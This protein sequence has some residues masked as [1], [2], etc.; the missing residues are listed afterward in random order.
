MG[1]QKYDP[2]DL[3]PGPSTG[4]T[5]PPDSFHDQM[6]IPLSNL[7]AS[8]SR[9]DTPRYDP[10]HAGAR[11]DPRHASIGS[12]DVLSGI[13]RKMEHSYQEFDPSKNASEAHLAF[14]EGDLPNNKASKL[15]NYL[16]N[17]SIVSRW[18]LFIVPVM[19][20]IWIPGIIVLTSTGK[21]HQAQASLLATVWGVGLLWWSI[22]LSVC[23]GGWWAALAASMILPRIIR[24]TVGVIAVG[25]RRYMDWLQALHRYCALFFWTLAV[26]ISYNPLINSRQLPTASA[27]SIKI[28]DL[29]QK[30][31]FAF[32]LCAAVLLGEKFSIQWIAGKFHE[33]SYA[34]RIADQKFAIKSIVTLYTHSRNIARPDALQ[35]DGIK[36]FMNPR[37]F[38]KRALK[39][40]RDA[41]TT[42]TTAFGNV[43]SEITGSS[44]L[45]PNSPQSIVQTALESANRSRLLAR[46]LF[47]SFA[48]PNADYI[49][50]EDIARFF[51]TPDEADLVFALFDQDSN[52]DA[53]RDEVEMAMMEFHREQ[54][55]IE[56]SMQDLDSA[57]GRLDNIFMSLYVV[58]AILIIAVALEAQVA[59]LVTSAGTLV[60]GLSWLIGGTL[61]EVLTSIIFLFIKHPF[62]V[63]DRVCIDKT[64]YTVKE[65]RL[66][67]TIFLNSDGVSVQAPNTV[68]NSQMSESFTFDVNYSTSF[69]DV[70]KLRQRMLTF[71]TT[72][73]RDYQPAFD[74]VVVD[75]PDQ[76]KMTLQADIKYKSN[77]QQGALKAKR[78]NKWLCALKA[79]LAEVGIYGPSG[80]PHSE[81]GT[82]RYT[83]VP[84]HEV[85]AES[86]KAKT[87]KEKMPSAQ[88]PEGGWRLSG[89]NAVI[90]EFV[91]LTR[92]WF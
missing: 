12:W 79:A 87:S 18:I 34:E 32:F 78:R 16:L 54:L 37:N 76:S 82:Q 55:S 49:L 70:E 89:Q 6:S 17:V 4:H 22:W 61:A 64:N 30:L 69:E 84:W 5:Y 39:G 33:K 41:A 23:W 46:R 35:S 58:I 21:L 66:L 59:T 56:H 19:G 48:K 26:F 83:E 9:T 2:V 14:A 77:G 3:E 1:S 88:V 60:L 8:S 71:V 7:P 29:I 15:Y 81:P 11:P 85:K 80:N 74:I 45:Q 68:L 25:T 27:N 28:I 65:I 10:E 91:W 51:P 62:D 42:T 52:G 44:V 75:F 90:R 31:T 36:D 57:V 63:G 43:A 47:Y 13:G 24:R 53:S 38:L 72:E 20:I 50:V 92:Y 73:R 40:V 67:S 86:E